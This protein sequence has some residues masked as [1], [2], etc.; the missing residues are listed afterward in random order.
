MRSADRDGLAGELLGLRVLAAA[1]VD[2]S[3]HLPPERLRR[4]VLLVAELAAEAGERLGL[5]VASERAERAAEQRRV[6]GEEGALAAGLE[7]V[8]VAA[9]VRGRVLVAAGRR[10]DVAERE[11]DRVVTEQVAEALAG[12]ARELGC[13]FEA[14]EHGQQP[15]PHQQQPG[16]RVFG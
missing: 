8:A 6:G 1:G 12:L 4:G 2:E 7:Q 11:V 15:G 5:V 10:R 9:E 14:G 13:L 16:M 3:L